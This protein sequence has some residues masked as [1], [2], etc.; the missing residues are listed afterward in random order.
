LEKLTN[1][2]VLYLSRTPV[3]DL[4]PLA[5]LAKLRSVEITGTKVANAQIER[6][7]NARQAAGLEEVV[8]D[9]Y[10]GRDK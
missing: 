3:G 7:R 4:M 2:T 8:I 1:L 9:Q 6:F 5:K 10:G